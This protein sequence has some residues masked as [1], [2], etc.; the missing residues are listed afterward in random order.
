[1]KNE[2]RTGLL[3]PTEAEALAAIYT[4]RIVSTGHLRAWLSPDT[5][6]G[7]YLGYCLASLRERGLVAN[8]GRR[9]RSELLWYAT[10][11]GAAVAEDSGR[12]V[13]RAWRLDPDKV[14]GLDA[15]H[16]LAVN[17]LGTVML[18]EIRASGHD[19]TPLDWSHEVAHPTGRGRG[20]N[21][22]ADAVVRW[23]EHPQ[24]GPTRHGVMFVELDR[25]T[26]S[27]TRLVDKLRA[28][29]LYL[30]NGAAHRRAVY[31]SEWPCL[32]IV[33]DNGTEAALR[34]RARDVAEVVRADDDLLKACR[35][36]RA[37]ISTLDVLR[38]RGMTDA[39]MPE[40]APYPPPP[41]PRTYPKPEG[42]S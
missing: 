41:E 15:S 14:P 7:R 6:A 32:V 10:A 22:I 1:M 34:R 30:Q 33:L 37:C 23:S 8:A 16:T 42:W 29:Q 5:A 4:H 28:Y 24:D 13:P 26:M 38:E 39:T 31:G 18:A 2:L 40:I 25:A 19:M 11:N 12:V 20:E 27:V 17:D 35:R 9:G 36:F 21:V 3:S